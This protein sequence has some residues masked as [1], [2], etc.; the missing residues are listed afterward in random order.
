MERVTLF[1][2]WPGVSAGWKTGGER[3]QA[4]LPPQKGLQPQLEGL[5]RGPPGVPQSGP[6]PGSVPGE[7]GAGEEGRGLEA[8]QGV[9][10]LKVTGAVTLKQGYLSPGGEGAQPRGKKC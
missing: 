5:K 2:G 7:T 1:L 10:D 3:E 8:P 6:L 9:G 4:F